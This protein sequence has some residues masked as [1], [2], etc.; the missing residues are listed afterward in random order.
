MLSSG[1]RAHNGKILTR[2]QFKPLF[3]QQN[4]WMDMEKEQSYHGKKETVMH[5]IIVITTIISI[6]VHRQLQMTDKD[7]LELLLIVVPQRTNI[8]FL[9]LDIVQ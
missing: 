3:R 4:Y 7:M 2:H 5:F 9:F 8:T 6:R 1:T